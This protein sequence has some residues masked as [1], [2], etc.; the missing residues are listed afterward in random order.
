MTAR[1]LKR[2]LGGGSAPGFGL[3]AE[4]VRLQ[5]KHEL[6]QRD[7]DIGFHE[8]ALLDG[9]AV[10]GMPFHAL[11]RDC[12]LRSGTAVPPW[13]RLRRAQRAYQLAR[14]AEMT[15]AL[16]GSRAEC[17]VLRGLSGLLVAETLRR[18]APAFDLRQFFLIDSFEGLSAMHPADAVKLTG[19]GGAYSMREGDFGNTSAE[20]V[21]RVVHDCCS[22]VQ[23]W[24]PEVLDSLPEAA[25]AFVH[26]DVDL[27]EPTSGA[28][29]YF[30]PR[31]SPGAVVINDDYL[32][33]LFPGAGQAWDE[34]FAER[35]LPFVVL[36][37]GQAVFVNRP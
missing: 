7:A 33:P 22:V 35:G 19:A 13:K 29:E 34:F 28:L 36:D 27:Y 12:L 20:H 25:W 32:S 15:A 26:L 9:L 21:R 17:G 37:S 23:G 24:I 1:F 6:A 5:Q 11:Y 3:R 10:A 4:L 18:A 8:A 14:Y 31:L 16:P 30:V 2:L